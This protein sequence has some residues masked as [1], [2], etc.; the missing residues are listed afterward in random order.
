MVGWMELLLLS[1][2]C[3]RLTRLVVDDLIFEPI[4]ARFFQIIIKDEE[5]WLEPKGIIGELLSCHWCVGVWGAILVVF[6]HIY[7]PYSDL[8]ILIMALAGIQS[9]IYEWSV[10]K[11]E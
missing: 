6:L 11:E 10:P 8:F 7:V 2:A 4:R 3:F 9:I 1:F 5:E